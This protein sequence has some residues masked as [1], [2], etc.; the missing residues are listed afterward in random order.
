MTE[1]PPVVVLRAVGDL[2]CFSRPEFSVE[3]TSYPWITPSAARAL[4]EA[5]CWKPRIRYEVR[6]IRVLKPIRYI[7]FRRN[8]V[9]VKIATR[10]LG[11]ESRI[12]TDET[13]NRT[14]QQ[15]NTTALAN[16][17]Y[18]VRA[19]LHLNTEL[20]SQSPD[21]NH[22]KYVGIFN[23]RLADGQHF[24][25]PYLGCR[26]FAAD[27][28]PPIPGEDPI[29]ASV[30]HGPMLYD[31]KFPTTPDRHRDWQKGKKPRPLYFHARLEHGVLQVPPL[32]EILNQLPEHLR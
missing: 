5:V 30:D 28:T 7:S 12:L 9:G 27:L 29:A 24:H 11:P 22:G 4:F 6:E 2:A 19:E 18:E 23:R 3:R 32:A 20:A 25:Q 14:R 26:E 31:F 1:R 21:D 13:E 17:A 15:R 16:V 10:G 8:E